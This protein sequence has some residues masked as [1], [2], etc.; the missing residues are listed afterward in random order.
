M[1]FKNATLPEAR[2][3]LRPA[4][5]FFKTEPSG[6]IL[7]L[8]FTALALVWANSPL[9]EQYSSLWGT[10]VTI[11]GGSF[12][13][14]QT[15]IHWIN[16]G[17]MAIFF[18]LVGLEIKRE[19]LVGELTSLRS[20]A[21]PIAAALGGIALPATLYTILNAGTEGAAGWGIPIATDIA[22]ALGIMALL[23][24]KIPTSL[25]VFLTALAI[26]DDICAVLVIAL[27]YTADIALGPL[28]VA[29]LTLI[30]LVIVNRMDVRKPLVYA[31]LGVI[32]WLAFLQSGVHATVAG[33]LLAMTIPARSRIDP[34]AFVDKG[35]A[36][37]NDFE[38]ASGDGES[39]MVNQDRQHAVHALEVAAEQV[40]APLQR[41][42]HNLHGWVAF[43]IMP[44]FALANA[45][46]KLPDNIGETLAQP[47]TLGVMLGLIIGKPLGI[48]IAS[49]LV[50]R[51]GLADKPSDVSWKQIHGAAWL[52][53]IGFTMSLFIAGLAFGES[54]L[55]TV[56]K[57]GILLASL[58]AGII[59]YVILRRV[60]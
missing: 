36:L 32:L 53:G 46:V 55:L 34:D 33:V 24:D 17:L 20:A 6:G 7:L 37:L 4:H 38:A 19:V 9:S 1:T 25:K 22:F 52:A 18:V 58:V 40:Q 56:A 2:Q 10:Y 31:V 50:V 12:V 30:A 45:G 3:L 51:L 57:T 21:L 49:L 35:R 59:G 26:I 43:A 16:D 5:E 44:L 15:L 54:E 8:V 14:S 27:F 60:S 28:A 13:L 47:V 29:A 23:G 11:G 41:M 48:T 42:E 39:V